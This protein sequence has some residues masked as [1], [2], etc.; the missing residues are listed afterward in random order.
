MAKDY[1]EV[2][3]RCTDSPMGAGL[4]T[5]TTERGFPQVEHVAVAWLEMEDG[6]VFDPYNVRAKHKAERKEKANG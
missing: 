6:R 1:I 2:G 5:G 4:I 3:E